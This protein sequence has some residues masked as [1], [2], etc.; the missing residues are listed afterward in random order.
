MKST[1]VLLLLVCAA[2]QAYAATRAHKAF[3]TPLSLDA[4]Q[5]VR[6]SLVSAEDLMMAI[7]AV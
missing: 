7:S 2:A 4:A 1:I 6:I 3:I 5:V